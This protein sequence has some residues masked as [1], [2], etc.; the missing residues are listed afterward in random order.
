MPPIPN[1]SSGAFPGE[2]LLTASR[3]MSSA[4]LLLDDNL[5]DGT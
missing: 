2:H 3:V 1:D 5:I 4:I